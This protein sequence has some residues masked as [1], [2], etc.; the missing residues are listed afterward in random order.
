[1]NELP[2]HRP[3]GDLRVRSL[4]VLQ[5]H[6]PAALPWHNIP[7]NLVQQQL[8][9]RFINGTDREVD[10]IWINNEDHTR[11]GKLKRREFIDINTYAG[12][13]EICDKNKKFRTSLDFSRLRRRRTF[14]Y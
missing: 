12:M 5:G 3:R 14:Y 4:R 1:M 13:L 8:K 11:Y 10:C 7:G 2:H 6:I 9:Y